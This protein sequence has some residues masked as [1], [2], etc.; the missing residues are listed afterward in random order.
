[1]TQLP[2][3]HVHPETLG[4]FPAHRDREPHVQRELAAATHLVLAV[5][6]SDQDAQR[7]PLQIVADLQVAFGHDVDECVRWLTG[8]QR[9]VMPFG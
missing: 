2:A 8:R 9:C 3:I 6:I 5:S 7:R 1:M 4:P